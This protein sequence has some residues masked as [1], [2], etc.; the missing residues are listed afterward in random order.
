M[1]ESMLRIAGM[2]SECSL[3]DI[4]DIFENFILTREFEY[5]PHN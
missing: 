5:V 1:I 4:Q 2:G 3:A